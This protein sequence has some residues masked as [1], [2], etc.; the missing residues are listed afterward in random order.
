[1]IRAIYKAAGR[2]EPV[3]VR[4][5]RRAEGREGAYLLTV[6]GHT[7]EIEVLGEAGGQ[8]VIRAGGRVHR[9]HAARRDGTVF[10]WLDGRTYV[11]EAVD[12]TVRR[13]GGAAAAGPAGGAITAPMPGTVLKILAGPGDTIEAHQALVVM[14]SMKME[15]TLSAPRAGR[16]KEV[17][18]R[19]GELVEMGRVLV[20]LDEAGDGDAG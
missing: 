5:E 9:Y 17:R 4:L 20:T 12:R 13:A 16:V 15:M 14:E 11:L 1:M 6:G 18:C 3:E 8:G 7:A 19:A 10:V 2:E